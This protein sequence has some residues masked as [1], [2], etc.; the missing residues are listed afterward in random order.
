MFELDLRLDVL[1]KIVDPEQ[2]AMI[3]IFLEQ[4]MDLLQLELVLFWHY[5]LGDLPGYAVLTREEPRVMKNL[6][7]SSCINISIH[8]FHRIRI[9]ENN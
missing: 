8:H 9:P 5:E 4:T 7:F 3:V 6:L 2:L 1:W